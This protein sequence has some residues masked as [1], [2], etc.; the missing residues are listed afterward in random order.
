M[1]R[2]CPRSRA[3]RGLPARLEQQGDGLTLHIADA[4]P[5]V[6]PPALA[7]R[8]R[9]HAGR[10]VEFGIR[11]E[12]L[13]LDQQHAQWPVIEAEVELVE[14]LGAEN[15]LTLK[16]GALELKARL[17]PHVRPALGTRLPIALDPAHFHL[18]DTRSGRV[19]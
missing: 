10:A 5:L 6:L 17:P 13:S 14:L 19:I 2:W 9:A 3:P 1:A 16:L 8:W 7:Q 15:L 4:K 12:N 18:F 11:P